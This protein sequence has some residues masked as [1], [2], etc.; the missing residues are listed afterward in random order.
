CGIFVQICRHLLSLVCAD[1]EIEDYG[2][3]YFEE[4]PEEKDVD[5][6]NR[7][8]KRNSPVILITQQL[9]ISTPPTKMVISRIAGRTQLKL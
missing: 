9:S 7:Y 3:E 6:E 4:E 1:A 8:S 5:F 2:F